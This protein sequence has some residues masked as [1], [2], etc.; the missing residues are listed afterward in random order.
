MG[1]SCEFCKFS[2]NTFFIEHL[3]WLLL[4]VLRKQCS[5][6]ID[7]HLEKAVPQNNCSSVAVKIVYFC[8]MEA[9][10]RKCSVKKVFLKSSQR[11]QQN[12]C[13]GSSFVIVF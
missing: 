2:K 6:K 8:I 13:A 9:V 3:R 1:V 5:I 11:L 12:T 10:A 4:H 7:G